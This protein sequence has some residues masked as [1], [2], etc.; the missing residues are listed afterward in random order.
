M[1]KTK[2]VIF[3]N[4]EQTGDGKVQDARLMAHAKCP[5]EEWKRKQLS[6][7]ILDHIKD[8][9]DTSPLHGGNTNLFELYLVD[10]E[11]GMNRFV[12]TLS[13]QVD[14][15]IAFANDTLDTFVTTPLIEVSK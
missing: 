12:E 15:R 14:E 4:V 10:T 6:K 7:F 11:G 2:F 8:N 3:L 13:S 1:D 9:F 5:P